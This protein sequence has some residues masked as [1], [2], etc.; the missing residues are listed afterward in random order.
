MNTIDNQ[1]YQADKGK[2]IVRIEDDFIMGPDIDLGSE[3]SI[4]NYEE[5]KFTEKEIKDFYE[6]I[7]LTYPFKFRKNR[8]DR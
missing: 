2:L 5:R 4:E 6:S 1:H 7:G 3:D 8:Y